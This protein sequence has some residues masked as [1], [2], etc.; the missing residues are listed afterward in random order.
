MP[1]WSDGAVLAI[2]YGTFVIFAVLAAA[3][4]AVAVVS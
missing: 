4:I 3:L 2:V 1:G